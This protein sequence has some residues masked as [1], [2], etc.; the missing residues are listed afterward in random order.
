MK[1]LSLEQ[2]NERS[3]I[4]VYF[5]FSICDVILTSNLILLVLSKLHMG[6]YESRR[7][8]LIDVSRSVRQWYTKHILNTH[9]ILLQRSAYIKF[10]AYVQFQRI[11]GLETT[12]QH[13]TILTKKLLLFW[14][15][16]L[17]IHVKSIL[18]CSNKRRSLL[19]NSLQSFVWRNFL[20]P[21]VILPLMVYRIT[22]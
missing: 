20:F 5:W 9:M 17:L 15:L 10:S 12:S 4:F 22:I 16:D 3:S 18:L 19:K 2:Y 8:F 7:W 6:R 13:C 14:N 1:H 11:Y 21:I